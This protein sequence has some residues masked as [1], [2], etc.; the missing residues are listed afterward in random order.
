MR[1]ARLGFSVAGFVFALA[2]VLLDDRRLAWAA[3]GLLAASFL[4]RI[5][6]R[7]HEDP[8]V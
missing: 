3:I 2:A 1:A 8:E 4:L 7:R 6:S 5:L